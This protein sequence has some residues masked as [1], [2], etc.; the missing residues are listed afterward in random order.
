MD[1]LKELVAFIAFVWSPVAQLAPLELRFILL[2]FALHANVFW[3]AS[4]E[5][6]I[7]DLPGLTI[8]LC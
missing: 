5:R 2:V 6:C 1:S 7:D 8:R 3:S 4:P